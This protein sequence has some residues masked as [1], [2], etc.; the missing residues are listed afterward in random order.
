MGQGQNVKTFWKFY[1]VL[2]LLVGGFTVG[3]S[4]P[5]RGAYE[6][7]PE[8]RHVWQERDITY[9]L[10]KLDSEYTSDVLLYDI[11]LDT[12]AQWLAGQDR[13]DVGV[14]SVTG[15]EFLQKQRLRLTRDLGARAYF[16]FQ[17][18]QELD[19]ESEMNEFY[20]AV[21]GTPFAAVPSLTIELFGN[22]DFQKSSNDVGLAIAKTFERV[23]AFRLTV[24][25]PDFQRNKRQI[26]GVTWLKEPW[27]YNL[28]FIDKRLQHRWTVRFDPES[29]RRDQLRAEDQSRTS[30]VVTG[31]SR[32][33]RFQFKDRHDE[34]NGE[35]LK[36]QQILAG[37]Q[38]DGPVRLGT[39]VLYRK[40]SR[41][42]TSARLFELWPNVWYSF[43][44]SH[45]AMGLEALTVDENDP[46]N[47]LTKISGDRI[48]TRLNFTY[49]I[50]MGERGSL[51]LLMAADLDRRDGGGLWEGGA[52]HLSF[53]F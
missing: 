27:S 32:F 4:S 28:R 3:L 39:D 21:G 5:G 10:G 37:V 46:Q 20:W 9:T 53:N 24:F 31:K 34:L 17:F 26:D 48:E 42:N 23:G 2:S 45:W 40:F 49:T 36:A 47:V 29:E 30:V 1:H 33:Y 18:F 44:R 11:Q 22:T 15:K 14:G 12:E 41:G 19:F 35:V 8:Y 16:Q 7:N 52:G 25:R 13:Y 6:L 38:W 50:A 43:P 51:R